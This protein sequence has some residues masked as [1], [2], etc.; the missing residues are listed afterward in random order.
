MKKFLKEYRVELLALLIIVLGIFLLVERLE[1]RQTIWGWLQA[2]G[3][4][5]R[6]F[7]VNIKDW[8][9]NYINTFTLSDLTGWILIILTTIFIA[10]RIR[11]RFLQS[12]YWRATSCPKCGSQNLQRVHRTWFD[13]ILSYILMPH[14]HRYKCPTRE[15]G[16]S[17]LRHQ[18]RQ[19][20]SEDG[21]NHAVSK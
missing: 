9:A 1:I 3:P 20:I 21:E 14:A 2:A 8:V 19:H 16:W 12:R 5:G 7:L 11:Y 4:G 15:C 17:G 13:R 18:Q 10:W 6:Q